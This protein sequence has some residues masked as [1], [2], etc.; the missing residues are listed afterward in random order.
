MH[1]VVEKMTIRSSHNPPQNYE[2]TG[3]KLE[4]IGQFTGPARFD[5]SLYFI[6]LY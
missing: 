2:N 3:I 1:A 6:I 5:I 4:K